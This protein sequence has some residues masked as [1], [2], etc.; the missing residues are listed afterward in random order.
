MSDIAKLK[1]QLSK[2][3][4]AVEE[5]RDAM[6]VRIGSFAEACSVAAVLRDQ[7]DQAETLET[8]A[9]LRSGKKAAG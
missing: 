5:A 2:A 7:L 6:T 3:D 4:A 1:K 8:A 9:A